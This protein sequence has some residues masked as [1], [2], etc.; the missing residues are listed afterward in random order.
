MTW[1]EFL[2][3]PLEETTKQVWTD[4][5]C[6]KCGKKHIYMDSSYRI[7]TY[8]SKYRYWCTCGW[9]GYAPTMWAERKE[10]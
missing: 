7:L 9:T 3:I 6:P 10:E 1:E 5:L 2:C 8:P 4:I